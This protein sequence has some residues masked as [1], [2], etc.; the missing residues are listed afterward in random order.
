MEKVQEDI[1]L[2]LKEVAKL[3]DKIDAILETKGDGKK[4]GDFLGLNLD[5]DFEDEEPQRKAYLRFV[6]LW[7]SKTRVFPDVKMGIQLIEKIEQLWIQTLPQK[8]RPIPRK[9]WRTWQNVVGTRESD[10]RD[11]RYFALVGIGAAIKV[12]KKKSQPGLLL[13]DYEEAITA[14]KNSATKQYK[15]FV[16]FLDEKFRAYAINFSFLLASTF[17]ELTKGQAKETLLADYRGLT[18]EQDEAL[19]GTPVKTTISS[20]NKQEETETPLANKMGGLNLNNQFNLVEDEEEE[21]E[22]MDVA[23]KKPTSKRKTPSTRSAASKSKRG[24][25]GKTPK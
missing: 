8:K 18:P 2:L 24:R 22:I 15:Q 14:L 7:K 12:M 20:E 13:A 5:D 1:T 11:E 23:G 21:V 25:G 9:G 10:G 16:A 17:S 6:C 3:N 4:D 19:Q